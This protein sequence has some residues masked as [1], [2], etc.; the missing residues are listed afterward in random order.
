MLTSKEII[1]ELQFNDKYLDEDYKNSKYYRI[2]LKQVFF[3]LLN[4]TKPQE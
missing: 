3:E 2:Y 1:E 4:L